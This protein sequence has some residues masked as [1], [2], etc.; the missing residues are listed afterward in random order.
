MW[1]GLRVLLSTAVSPTPS[2]IVPPTS[3]AAP[4]G[5]LDRQLVRLLADMVLATQ[6]EVHHAQ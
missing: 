2:L 3:A 6:L 5:T 1:Q 4:T